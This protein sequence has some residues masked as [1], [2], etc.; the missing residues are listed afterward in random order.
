MLPSRSTSS[1]EISLSFSIRYSACVLPLKQDSGGAIVGRIGDGGTGEGRKGA[2]DAIAVGL[3]VGSGA[4]VGTR[5]VPGKGVFKGGIVGSAKG[6]LLGSMLML[7][8]ML[9]GKPA[10][11]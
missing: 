8:L 2:W 1:F 9:V 6:L 4:D 11:R 5:D 3:I 7:I 10:S